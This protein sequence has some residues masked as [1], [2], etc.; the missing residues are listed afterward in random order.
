MPGTSGLFKKKKHQNFENKFCPRQRSRPGQVVCS[1]THK[2]ERETNLPRAAKLPRTSDL[3]KENVRFLK[4]FCPKQRNC[5]RQVASS[6]KTFLRNSSAPISGNKS[7]PGS[8]AAPD[9]RL[10]Q[11]T[12]G[13]L[14]NKSGNEAARD[15]WLLQKENIFLLTI[16]PQTAKLPGTS[17]L[18][19]KKVIF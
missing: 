17:G 2:K 6:E 10:L 15:K 13:F 18:F 11:K 3:V 1:K 14:R 16:L 8:A 5:P 4:K 12:I 9:K 19:K 7:A